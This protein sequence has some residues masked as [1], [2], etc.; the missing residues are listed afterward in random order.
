MEDRSNPV[1]EQCLVVEQSELMPDIFSLWL[2]TD[3]IAAMA[4]PGQFVN[5]YCR[6]TGRLLPRPVSLCEILPGQQMIRL[7]YRAGGSRTGTR[8]FTRLRPSDTVFLSGPVGNGFPVD[9]TEGGRLM[10]IGGGIGIP[11]LLQAGRSHLGSTVFV[12]GYRNTTFLTKEFSETGE[13]FLA[14][15]DGCVGTAGTVLDAV[16]AHQ[17]KADAVF[18]CG[19]LP[20]LKAVSDWAGE[21]DIPCWISLE[22]RMACGIGACLGCVCRTT[23]EHPHFHTPSARVCR[24][25]P[26]FLS[27]EVVL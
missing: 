22:E 21:E 4:A 2:K 11:P 26:V 24:E 18:A 15:E 10:L 14:T 23:K 13:V 27:T 5:V 6:D 3:R 9:R 12:L 17:L 20:M 25:G 7:V 19:P 16:R 8:E 1:Y